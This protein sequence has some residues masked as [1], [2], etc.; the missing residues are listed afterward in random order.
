MAGYSAAVKLNNLVIT[1]FT[2]LGNGVSNYTAQNLGA[3]KLSRIQDGF[4]A[5][6]RLVW[7]LCL[8]MFL[9]YFFAGRYALGLFLDHPT[10]TAL[11]TGILYLRILS[12][13]YFIVSAKLV[14]DGVLR[15]AGLMRQFYDWNPGGPGPSRNPGR[16]VG[17]D[18]PGRGGH[19][20]CVARRLVYC[21]YNFSGLLPR[22]SLDG[23]CEK[24]KNRE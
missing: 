1:S 22:R 9:L 17:K 21:C 19:L 13:F 15:G 8:P 7:T 2:T 4:R 10:D 3:H 11:R 16:G 12:P 23:V 20:V 24:G 14:S 5:G 6:V 18:L